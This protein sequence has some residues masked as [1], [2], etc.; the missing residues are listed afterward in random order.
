[1]QV[2]WLVINGALNF[3]LTGAQ[4][5]GFSVTTRDNPAGGENPVY[6]KKILPQGAAIVDGRL[7]S[8]DRLLRV[9]EH[10]FLSVH[11]QN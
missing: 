8:G 6:I 2:Y 1:M 3:I 9:R 4:G 10:Y 11:C 7:Q 5:L